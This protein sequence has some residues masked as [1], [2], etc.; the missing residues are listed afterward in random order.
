[1]VTATRNPEPRTQV[2]E[3][4]I[5][6][7]ARSSR[8][9][10]PSTWATCCVPCGLDIGAA[11]VRPA[12]VVFIRGANSQQSIVMID[13]VRINA[14]TVGGAPLQNLAPELFSGSRSS[15][16]RVPRS[17]APSHRRRG[18]LHQRSAGPSGADVMLDYGAT[19]RRGRR[20]GI[21]TT[22]TQPARRS[23]PALG[24]IPDF[25]RRHG[26]QRLQESVRRRR[27][28][29]QVRRRRRGR[30][31]LAVVRHDAYAKATTTGRHFTGFG[32]L[33]ERFS[34][35]ALAVHASGD[36][37]DLWHARLTL[38]RI[39]DDLRQDQPDPYSAPPEPAGAISTTP[40]ETPWTCRTT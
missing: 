40:R 31:V 9:R 38:S 34:N 39:I 33:D 17:T 26:E 27:R 36:L 3:S 21:Y 14:G 18:Q 29:D 13:G 11:G 30:V 2:L 25:R 19:R 12:A 16:V 4:V 32:H 6:S 28:L 15:K 7:T 35:S 22:A 37:T 5:L 8:T 1:V 24:W 10:S 20:D 23:R